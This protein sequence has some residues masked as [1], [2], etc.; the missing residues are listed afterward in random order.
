MATSLSFPAPTGGA[1][2]LLSFKFERKTVVIIGS[3]ALAAARAF[4]ALEADA[5]VI[6]LTAGGDV[7]EELRWRS[8]QG[9]L[10]LVDPSA[11]PGSST[12]EFQRASKPP[13]RHRHGARTRRQAPTLTELGCG[14][15]PRLQLARN[16][17]QR[18]GHTGPV[19]LLVY[20]H[21][22]LRRSGLGHA[23]PASGRRHHEREGLPPG[24]PGP[25]G[26]RLAAT[27]GGCERDKQY[28]AL[29]RSSEGGRG[30]T[31]K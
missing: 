24:R 16:P 4:A 12:G 14:H 9:Q 15:T 5:K 11:L 20:L 28:R 31:F 10:S 17:G 2:L 8:A 29:A 18:D 6:V 22:P 19:R 27:E 23:Q 21:A 25:T 13:M 1:S 3:G 7:C 30:R 26:D